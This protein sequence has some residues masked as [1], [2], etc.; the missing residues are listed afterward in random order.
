ML[1]FNCHSIGQLKSVVLLV[2]DWLLNTLTALSQTYYLC[3]SHSTTLATQTGLMYGLSAH[4]QYTVI[5]FIFYHPLSLYLHASHPNLTFYFTLL[6]SLSCFISHLLVVTP[7]H[8]VIQQKTRGVFYFGVPPSYTDMLI[9]LLAA[10]VPLT[11]KSSSTPH[12][13]TKPPLSS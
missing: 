3:Q 2:K 8:L 1:Q 7:H 11:H 4:L 6:H 9:F 13:L 12:N 5:Y 10:Q